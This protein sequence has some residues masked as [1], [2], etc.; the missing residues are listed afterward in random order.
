MSRLRRKL[1]GFTMSDCL[2]TVRN[3]GY[4]PRRTRPTRLTG[5]ETH[6]PRQP[7]RPAADGRTAGCDRRGDRPERLA[8]SALAATDP[9]AGLA[10]G[11][12]RRHP[13]HG[14]ACRPRGRADGPARRLRRDHARRR[15]RAGTAARAPHRG[16]ACRGEG[17]VADEHAGARAARLHR[18]RPETGSPIPARGS[19]ASSAARCC[20]CR[21]ASIS[22]SA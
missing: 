6:R 12:G 22:S 20:R 17:G 10:H 8:A 11:A 19:K 2:K 7:R 13:R 9:A 16:A 18:R 5:R 21:R 4:I 3:A 1:A 15:S 14:A